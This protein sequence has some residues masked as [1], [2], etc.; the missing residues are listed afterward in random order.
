MA[1]TFG[2][3]TR[4]L[5][6]ISKEGYFSWNIKYGRGTRKSDMATILACKSKI[7]RYKIDTQTARFRAHYDM[8]GV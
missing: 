1:N 3:E 7:N 2:I 4:L 5:S 6:M 8:D